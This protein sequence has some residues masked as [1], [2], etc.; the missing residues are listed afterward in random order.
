MHD[1]QLANEEAAG[2]AKLATVQQ[3]QRTLHD[4]AKQLDYLDLMGTTVD[5]SSLGEQQSEL[6][7]IFNTLNANR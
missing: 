4:V 1:W 5:T 3:L 2:I 6:V 7:S